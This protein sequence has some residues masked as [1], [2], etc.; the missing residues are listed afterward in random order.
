MAPRKTYHNQITERKAQAK[1]SKRM[2]QIF[3]GKSFSFSGDFGENWTH[4]QMAQWIKVHGGRYER[5]VSDDT[6]HLICTI[7]DYK[8]KTRQ[9]NFHLN[10]FSAHC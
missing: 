10:P 1:S 5:E 7:S 4:E 3:V 2:K 8:A 9:G 6:T